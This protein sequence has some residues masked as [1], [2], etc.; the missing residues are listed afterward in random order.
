MLA[1]MVVQATDY[2]HSQIIEHRLKVRIQYVLLASAFPFYNANLSQTH[3][4][5]HT[6]EVL[7]FLL[8]HSLRRYVPKC[9]QKTKLKN[10]TK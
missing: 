7:I 10:Q 1:K 4:T 2:V 9:I 5:L 6:R 8:L 3:R